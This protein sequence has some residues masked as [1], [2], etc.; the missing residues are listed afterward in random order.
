[1]YAHI[2]MIPVYIQSIDLKLYLCILYLLPLT[3]H[4]ISPNV[5]IILIIW[6]LILTLLRKCN[7]DPK[8][9]S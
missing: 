5:S 4:K 6:T 1:M 8:Q 3:S 7:I 9:N 2:H